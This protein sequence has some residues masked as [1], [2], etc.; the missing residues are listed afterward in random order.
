[1]IAAAVP[2]ALMIGLLALQL[3]TVE[4]QRRIAARQEGRARVSLNEIEQ[5]ARRAR[6]AAPGLLD[7]LRRADGLVR[8]LARTDS[9]EAIAEAGRLAERLRT[10][11]LAGRVEIIAR[12]VVET[13]ERVRDLE[14]IARDLE[15]VARDTGSDVEVLKAETLEFQREILAIQRETLAVLQRSQEI[16]EELLARVRSIDE[17]TGGAVTPP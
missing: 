16:Q 6:S 11:D 12:A 5:Q 13:V 2:M 1:M 9:P 3:V 15:A 4:R 10:A 8:A 17:R 14:A 7:G